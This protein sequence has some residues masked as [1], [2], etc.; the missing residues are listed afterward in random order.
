MSELLESKV[1]QILSDKYIVIAIGALAG[2]KAGMTFVV[3]AQGEEVKDPASGAVLGRWEL[4]KGYLRATHVQ[5]RITTCE[6]IP[7]PG[8]DSRA[9]DE[10][11]GVLSAT[12]IADSLRPETW[13]G[14][15]GRLNVNRAQV[16]GVP[17]IG[18]ISVGDSVRECRLEPAGWL[19]MKILR[20]A[21]TDLSAALR[22]LS[23]K[24]GLGGGMVSESSR[25]KTLEIFGEALTP[26]E[27]VRRIL[28]D[29]RARGDEA[30]SEYA[31][32]LDG[33]TL[34]PE[35]FLV[36]RKEMEAAWRS[37]PAS[38][39]KSLARASANIRRFQERIK[40]KA[41]APMRNPEGGRL[42]VEYRPLARVGLCVP[43]GR[44]A[45]PSSA[46]MTA[47]PAQVAGVDEI[48]MVTPCRPDGTVRPETLAA[49]READL[50]EVYRISGAHAV[51]GLAYGTKTIRRV[52]K[53]VGPG[54]IF[55]TLAKREVYGEVALDMLAG[56]S[57][58]L[59][60]AD[61]KADPRFAAAD[62]LSQAEH[63]PAAAVLLTPDERVAR[64]TLAE[65]ERQ[66]PKLSREKAARDSL[67][68]YGFIAVT[69]DLDQAI[70][71]A[72][73]FAPEHLELAVE[74]PDALLGRI[75][76]AGAVFMG[77]YTPE[78]VGD[79]LA[80]PSHVLPTGG[81][82]RFFSGL[83][84]N[85]F[86]RRMSVIRYT[87]SALKKSVADVDSLARAEGLDAHARAAEHPV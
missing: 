25:R 3:L 12:M 68:R 75:R 74:D 49:A 82:A 10:T 4:P 58:V 78:P 56:P 40:L 23:S 42:A 66:L 47:I 76:C 72:N 11:T 46:L 61:A 85:D 38:F 36:T 65:I 37:V 64:E 73:Q 86:L 24:L 69:R 59:I 62:L 63:D 18:P 28:R 45:Y 51:A 15:G 1:A 35:K 60:I 9:T 2:A 81:T 50:T 31:S 7:A 27:V 53:I 34:P 14:S 80:G 32:K 17:R 22:E 16:A 33:A 41:P 26:L 52:D 48:A 21:E 84:V 44:A 67:E 39:R 6:G 43:G 83:S 8:Q 77:A 54:N 71:L 30:I 13:G 70:V 29:V 79:Y 19:A 5:E 55:V 20:A 57:E 87:P